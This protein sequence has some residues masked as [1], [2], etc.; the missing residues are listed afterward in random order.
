M[1][2][3]THAGQVVRLKVGIS[4]ISKEQARRNAESEISGFDFEQARSAAEQAWDKALAPIK[5]EGASEDEL[6]Q[7]STAVYHTMFQPTDHTEENPLFVSS[8][9]M[10]D[11]FYAIWDTFRT[12]TPLLT[13]IA[14]D[15]ES[16]IVRSLVDLYRHEGWMPDARSGAYSGR[17]Q[18]GTDADMVVVDGYLKHLPGVDWNEAYRA[19]VNDAE[20][21]PPNPIMVGRGDLEDWLQRG[22]LT[23]EGTDRP[24][25][26][27]M[28]YAANDYA[29][30]LFAKGLGKEADYRKYV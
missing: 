4:F 26:K 24:A 11:D 8:E 23:I 28:E 6:R 12:S 16:G 3:K 1:S 27:Q 21:T 14:E 25:S 13:I 29:I 2:F 18:G 10:Y 30:A 9:P 22:Y 17:E 20:H 19:V 5:I 15:R 7:F